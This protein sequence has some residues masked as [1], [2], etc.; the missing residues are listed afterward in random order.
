MYSAL[1]PNWRVERKRECLRLSLPFDRAG[2]KGSL[3]YPEIELSWAARADALINRIEVYTYRDARA[4]A[5]VV[6]KKMHLDAR[7]VGK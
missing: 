5:R 2:E 6:R 4:R 1:F 3:N 7:L